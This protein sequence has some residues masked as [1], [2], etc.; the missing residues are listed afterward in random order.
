MKSVHIH[1]VLLFFFGLILNI[2]SAPSWINFQLN[3]NSTAG[4]YHISIINVFYNITYNLELYNNITTDINNIN[5]QLFINTFYPLYLDGWYSQNQINHTN[6]IC[7]D[8]SSSIG[9]M[10]KGLFLYFVTRYP[11][12]STGYYIQNTKSQIPCPGNLYT[13]TEYKSGNIPYGYLEAHIN[14]NGQE[15]VIEQIHGNYF[16]FILTNNTSNIYPTPTPYQDPCDHQIP[17]NILIAII[18]PFS[19][20]LLIFSFIILY[21]IY[22]LRIKKQNDAKI[23]EEF[24]LPLNKPTYSYS[25]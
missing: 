11:I 25:A 14:I 21:L 2:N 10:Q 5:N 22:L 17:Q 23:L 24:K 8:Q 7:L 12:L 1:K 3:F 13:P 16:E 20:V 18:V 6:S 19:L 4:P 15:D 9:L